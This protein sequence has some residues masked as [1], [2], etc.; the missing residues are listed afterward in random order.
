MIGMKAS[1]PSARNL[2][3]RWLSPRVF[4]HGLGVG[5]VIGFLSVVSNSAFGQDSANVR[6]AMLASGGDSVA[7]CLH[8]PP[9]AKAKKDEAAIPFYCEVGPDGKAAFISLFGPEDKTAF[10]VALLKA[11]SI[12]HFQPAMSAAKRFLYCWEGRRSS[13]FVTAHQ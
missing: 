8:Y 1:K 12:G 4:V 13:C 5:L 9:K 2:I 6:P 3:N 11:L 7:A 10:R